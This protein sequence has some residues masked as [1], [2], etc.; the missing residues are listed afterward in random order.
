MK[1][2]L[3]MILAF[4]LVLGLLPAAAF[5]AAAE[6]VYMSISYDGQYIQGVNGPV[7]YIP[8]SMEDLEAI[9]LETYG[10]GDYVYDGNGDTILDLT[11]LHLYIY[12]HEQI[13]GL[14]WSDVRVSGSP[15]SIFFEAG[16]FGIADC[17]LN[18]YR[19]GAYPE[20]S[21]GWGATADNLVLESGDFFDIAGYTS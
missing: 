10:L 2:I 17:N 20:I 6:Y 7:A 21:P 4:V 13:M 15:G 9:E 12:T 1:R 18:Y 19:N 8:V 5:A 16:L 14:D 11:A 3:C